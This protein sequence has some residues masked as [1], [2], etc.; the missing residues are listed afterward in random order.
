MARYKRGGA[1]HQIRKRL[2]GFIGYSNFL[3]S[4]GICQLGSQLSIFPVN[5]MHFDLYVLTCII[6]LVPLVSA[7]DAVFEQRS[8]TLGTLLRIT[9][10]CSA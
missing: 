9:L 7:I 6:I 3:Q 8:P 5:F 4:Y 1:A 2:S 10:S